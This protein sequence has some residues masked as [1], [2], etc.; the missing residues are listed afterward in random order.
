MEWFHFYYEISRKG[1]FLS[2]MLIVIY[3]YYFRWGAPDFVRDFIKGIPYDVS[4][5]YYY[6]SDQFIWAR[7][8][9]GTLPG[10]A[11]GLP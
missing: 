2:L 1:R 6:G 10:N 3:I 4:E 9:L 7:E 8:F 11:N 5:G